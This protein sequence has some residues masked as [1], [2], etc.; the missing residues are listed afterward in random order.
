MSITL[1]IR[2]SGS[3][4]GHRG[5]RKEHR[6][7]VHPSVYSYLCVCVCVC[8]YV[9]TTEYMKIE[10]WDYSRTNKTEEERYLFFVLL[11]SAVLLDFTSMHTLQ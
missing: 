5:G 1:I 7:G 3:G 2:S 9:C 4:E 6:R 8:V 10:C 11:F